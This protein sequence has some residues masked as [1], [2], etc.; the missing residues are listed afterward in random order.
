MTQS[1]CIPHPRY[2]LLDEITQERLRQM[3]KGYT[4]ELDDLKQPYNWHED[5]TAYS[6]WARLMF[7]LHSPDK[8][9]RRYIQIAA[10]A[11]AAIESLDR[12]Q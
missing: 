2:D 7:D 8:A 4:P 9:R 6:G 12:R 10:L 1:K 11:M 3:N 5:I